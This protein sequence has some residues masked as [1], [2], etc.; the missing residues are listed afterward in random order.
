MVF[1]VRLEKYLSWSTDSWD[2]T[3]WRNLTAMTTS[4]TEEL[5]HTFPPLTAPAK[6]ASRDFVRFPTK[7]PAGDKSEQATDVK[8]IL[9]ALL[10]AQLIE[11]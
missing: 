9:L 11:L 3:V 4:L 8:A 2:K 1:P 7:F 10:C 6:K 5:I